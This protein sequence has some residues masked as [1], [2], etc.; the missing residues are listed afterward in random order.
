[1]TWHNMTWHDITWHDMTWHDLIL[2]YP[3]SPIL[4]FPLLILSLFLPPSP[5][6]LPPPP[7]SPSSLP[8]C[9]SLFLIPL[10][11]LIPNWPKDS[12][13]APSRAP[14]A[15]FHV[16]YPSRIHD[17]GEQSKGPSWLPGTTQHYATQQNTTQHN[18]TQHNLTLFT[19]VVRHYA[20]TT[21]SFPPLSPTSPTLHIAHYNPYSSLTTNDPWLALSPKCIMNINHLPKQLI[22]PSWFLLERSPDLRLP[23]IDEGG[24]CRNQS[25]PG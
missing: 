3:P 16:P 7:C 17:H 10:F 20:I 6:P 22:A 2:H 11:L 19:S 1:M 18:T 21:K 8:P 9:Y 25:H 13:L 14:Q 5:P 15:R 23:P 4:L 24:C 12:Q